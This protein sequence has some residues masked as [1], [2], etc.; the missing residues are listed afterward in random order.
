MPYTPPPPYRPRRHD[1]G[2][3][4]FGLALGLAIAL[5]MVPT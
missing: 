1:P 4:W 2:W 3:T 5:L